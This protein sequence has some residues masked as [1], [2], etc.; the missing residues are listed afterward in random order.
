VGEGEKVGGAPGSV[1]NDDGDGRIGGHVL[2]RQ[3]PRIHKI[4]KRGFLWIFSFFSTLL[5]LPPLRF[6][7]IE[8]WTV[9]TT[10]SAVRRSNHSARSRPLSQGLSHNKTLQGENIKQ[11]HIL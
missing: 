5:H 2:Y 9:A 11:F 4:F 10:A 7:C 3:R 1:K 6:H 8:P